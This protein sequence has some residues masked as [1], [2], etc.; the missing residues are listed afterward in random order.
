MTSSEWRAWVLVVLCFALAMVASASAQPTTG[1]ATGITSNNANI[2]ITGITDSIA[3]VEWGQNPGG[4][5]W[6]TSNYTATAGS[7][8]AQI[9]GA[10]VM[11]GTTYYAVACDDTGC[12]NEI[13]FTTLP[14]TPLPYTTFGA[15]YRNLTQSHFNISYIAPALF[16]AYTN[17]IPGTIFFGLFLGIIVIGLWRRNRGVRLVS[18]MFIIIS[19]LIMSSNI[20][21]MMGVPLIEQAIGQALLAAGIAGILLSFLKK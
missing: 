9:W 4:E 14:I 8:T 18:V 7:V 11:G 19:P 13:T 2:P 21:L 5:C 3:W 20:G 17:V 10:P 6:I 1:A 16:L 12:G 15:G